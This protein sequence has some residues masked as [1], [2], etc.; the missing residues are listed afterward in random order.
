MDVFGSFDYCTVTVNG[1]QEFYQGTYNPTSWEYHEIDLSAYAGMSNVEISFNLYTT[2]VVEYAGWYLDDIRLTGSTSQVHVTNHT[3]VWI[4]ATDNGTEPCIVGSVDL[5][6]T[7]EYQGGEIY[8]VSDYVEYM[9][10]WAHVMP[11][12]VDVFADNCT[13][14][15]NVTAVDDLGNTATYNVVF[16]VDN[17]APV[18]MVEQ[19]DPYCRNVTDSNPLVLNGSVVDLP[20]TVCASG[21]FN[22]S[23]W[24]R[25]AR[26]NHSF[27][28]WMWLN[29]NTSEADDWQYLFTAPNGSGYYQFY[30]SAYDNLGNHELPPNETAMPKA[31]VSVSYNHSFDLY[32]NAARDK[33][34]NWVTL[35]VKHPDILTASDLAMYVNMFAPD[36]CNMISVWDPVGQM[37]RTYVHPY[38]MGTVDD[39]VFEYGQGFM[40]HVR[41]NVT[42][43][44]MEGCLIEYDEISFRLY[45]SWNVVGWTCLEDTDMRQ[46]GENVSDTLKL[47]SYDAVQQ[48]YGPAF[49]LD[50]PAW[51][52]GLPPESIAIGEAVFLM[53]YDPDDAV[54][55][56]QWQGGREFLTLPP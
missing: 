29:T 21:V 35:P 9:G 52:V 39:F 43:V 56:M 37:Y 46:L 5:T 2:T 34:W 49:F 41:E 48:F 20:D 53:R 38:S 27:T 45:D 10:D 24:Y 15:M 26:Y 50:P 6:V 19:P 22:V 54:P 16:Y 36:V 55:S 28:D 42:D 33:G 32:F 47:M 13:H 18:S 1:N 51:A 8:N 31:L 3:P 4:N 14:Y 7:I 25:Y 11:D 44:Y 23:L 12:P 40:V 17:V 30:T